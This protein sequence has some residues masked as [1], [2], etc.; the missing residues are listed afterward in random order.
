[1]MDYIYCEYQLTKKSEVRKKTNTFSFINS[2]LEKRHIK[3]ITFLIG[4]T[5]VQFVYII[6]AWKK[7]ERA[8]LGH[9]SRFFLFI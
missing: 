4:N 9:E 2:F 7:G 8:I 1:M 6:R 3:L 5:Q